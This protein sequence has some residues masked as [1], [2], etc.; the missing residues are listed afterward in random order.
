MAAL[1]EPGYSTPITEAGENCLLAIARNEEGGKYD[2]DDGSTYLY[3]SVKLL[4]S[5][6][7][8]SR[9]PV[10]PRV[11]TIK[12]ELRPKMRCTFLV[13]NLNDM[14]S[15]LYLGNLKPVGDT[16][17]GVCSRLRLVII[18]VCIRCT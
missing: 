16:K 11:M 6:S 13:N 10:T 3:G 7:K 1:P 4:I 2:L 8:A 17:A 18:I 14:T 12:P 15:N 5:V 9:H